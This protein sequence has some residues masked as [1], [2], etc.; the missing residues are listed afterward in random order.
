MKKIF[1]KTPAYFI[2]AMIFITSCN[3]NTGSVNQNSQVSQETLDSVKTNEES[4]NQSLNWVWAKG[5]TGTIKSGGIL[6]KEG[7]SLITDSKGNVYV[8]GDFHGSTIEFDNV[9]SNSIG[10]GTWN[11]FFTKYDAKGNV[12]WVK[13]IKE[14]DAT[15]IAIDSKDDIYISCD[16]HFISKYNSDG[17]KIWE[18]STTMSSIS[19]AVKSPN[20]FYAVGTSNYPNCSVLKYDSEGN[21]LW[22]KELQPI[23]KEG[24]YNGGVQATVATDDLGNI[25]IAGGFSSAQLKFENTLLNMVGS[26]HGEME[27]TNGFIIKCDSNATC[28]WA[29][30]LGIEGSY[31]LTDFEQVAVD[32]NRNIYIAGFSLMYDRGILT[33]GKKS[34]SSDLIYLIKYDKDGN[35]L[36]SKSP[37]GCFNNTRPNNLVVN[38]FGNI[39]LTGCSW[40]QTLSFGQYEEHASEG[41]LSFIAK[42]NSNG[43]E[44]CTK[45]IVNVLGSKD[46]VISRCNDLATDISGNVFIT[47]NYEG[48]GLQFGNTKLPEPSRDCS[49]FIAKLNT[50]TA[51]SVSSSKENSETQKSETN[52]NSINSTKSFSDVQLTLTDASLKK[53]KLYLGEPDKYEFGFGHVT[54]GFAIYYDRVTDGNNSP[55]HLVLFLRMNGNQWGNSALIEE[56]YCVEDNQKICFGIHCIKIKNRKIYTN[57]LDLINDEGYEMY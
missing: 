42:Y 55:K 49:F 18:K 35:V 34:Y 20:S 57:A 37:S 3:N 29:K 21:I 39:Y 51:Q 19:I 31:N 1:L 12:I 30:N 25:Y 41:N 17:E 10:D 43:D 24:E 4:L 22:S 26:K 6:T 8:V 27:S 38:K 23:V 48:G 28:I 32:N 50:A 44:L 47:G 9:V 46:K 7:K 5:A 15:K 33:I 52:S 11:T 14:Y 16:G 36:W 13:I 54:K 45:S 56:I 53:A 2:A 40:C